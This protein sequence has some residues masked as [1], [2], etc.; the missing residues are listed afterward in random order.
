MAVKVSFVVPTRNSARTLDSCLVSLR[1]QTHREVEVVV[2][3]NHSTDATGDIALRLAHRFVLGGPERSAQRNLG[4]AHST[5][6]VVV[7]IDS[8][9]VLERQVAS[10]IERVFAEKS[11]TQALI[12]PERSFGD[13]F[14]AR[15][16]SFER[17]RYVGDDRV[18]APRAF[19]RPVI[20]ALGGWTEALVGP[21]DWD[22][23]DRAASAGV[24]VGRVDAWIW[25]DEGRIRLRDAFAK[26]RYYG[27]CIGHYLRMHRGAGS[28]RLMR[29]SLVR[30][31]TTLARHPVLTVGML[32][33]KASEAAGVLMGMRDARG[34]PD[35]PSVKPSSDSGIS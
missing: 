10:A 5:G 33:L 26:K 27:R 20:E 14:L 29:T 34:R 11:E 21:E 18:E 32:M 30:Q 6:E 16:K 4:M 15:C 28:R 7:F 23:A 22:L 8:D 19:R 1:H 2:V 24:R 31:P 25:H 17:I 9:M 13:G 3:D 12:I 35:V